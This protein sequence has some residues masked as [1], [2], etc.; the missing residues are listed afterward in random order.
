MIYIYIFQ[1]TKNEVPI[2]GNEAA[3]SIL[4]ADFM[5]DIQRKITDVRQAKSQKYS[6]QEGQINWFRIK[7][8]VDDLKVK[9]AA[10]S[11]KIKEEDSESSQ[12]ECLELAQDI[13]DQWNEIRAMLDG[14]M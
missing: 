14:E 8:N 12:R 5:E 3:E 7:E 11:R 9:C 10:L 4:P 2:M 1:C 6:Q 13:K